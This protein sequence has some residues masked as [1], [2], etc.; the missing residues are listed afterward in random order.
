MNILKWNAAYNEIKAQTKCDPNG[1]R[2]H[3]GI[4]NQQ[5]DFSHHLPVFLQAN[6][7]SIHT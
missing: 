2:N 6:L 7:T 1:G 3:K 5:G 4:E